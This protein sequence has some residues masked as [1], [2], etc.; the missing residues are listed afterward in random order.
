MYRIQRIALVLIL[1]TG[2]SACVVAVNDGWHNADWEEEQNHNRETIAGLALGSSMASVTAQLGAP[3]LSEA[4]MSGEDRYTVYFYRTQHRRSDG[5]T[6]R[7]ETTPLL[8]KNE[9]LLGWGNS[10]LAEFN[11]RVHLIAKE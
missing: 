11:A 8:F 5:D 3:D 7:N 1:A 4:Y 9:I 2:L 10:M 6:T